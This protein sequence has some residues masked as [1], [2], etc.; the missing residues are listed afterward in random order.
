MAR[1][2]HLADSGDLDNLI[3]ALHQAATHCEEWARQ[4]TE[5]Q[6]N[7]YAANSYRLLADRLENQR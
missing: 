7:Q 1:T 3:S 6:E 2:I 5:V 4:G